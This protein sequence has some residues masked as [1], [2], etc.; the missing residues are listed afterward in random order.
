MRLPENKQG[1]FRR[2]QPHFFS[3]DAE[4]VL[5]HRTP[6]CQNVQ[7]SRAP[8]TTKRISVSSNVFQSSFKVSIQS[9]PLSFME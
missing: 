3:W 2:A 5:Q 4:T 9:R 1:K 7:L 6:R 8:F